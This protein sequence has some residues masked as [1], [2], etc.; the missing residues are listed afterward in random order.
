MSATREQFECSA[1]LRHR[2]GERW[3]WIRSPRTG[4]V[5]EISGAW[6]QLLPKRIIART[7]KARSEGRA[8]VSF[9]RDELLAIKSI[10]ARDLPRP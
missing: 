6:A 2:S 8:M 3:F 10:H 1:G 9:S 5:L 4:K 7:A